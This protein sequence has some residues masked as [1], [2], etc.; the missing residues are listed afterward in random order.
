M[1]SLISRGLK[2]FFKSRFSRHI[3]RKNYKSGPRLVLGKTSKANK[4][5]SRIQNEFL[6]TRSGF[7]SKKIAN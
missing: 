2:D 7:L 6:M 1:R 3:K 4:F 5:M